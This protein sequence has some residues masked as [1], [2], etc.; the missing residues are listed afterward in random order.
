MARALL[1]QYASLAMIVSGLLIATSD[2]LLRVRVDD[3][4]TTGSRIPLEALAIQPLAR[5]RPFQ[6]GQAL[7]G[8]FL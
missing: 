6:L 3:D 5:S 8:A 7:I 1:C 2:H 4:G